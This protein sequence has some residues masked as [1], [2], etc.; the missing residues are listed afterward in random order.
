MAGG[1]LGEDLHIQAELL[2][3]LQ[4]G[5]LDIGAAPA[6]ADGVIPAVEVVPDAVGEVQQAGAVDRTVGVRIP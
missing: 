3:G 5:V 6:R 4:H 2:N 1:V